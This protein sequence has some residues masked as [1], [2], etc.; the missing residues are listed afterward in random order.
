[1]SPKRKPSR[2][3][4]YA[5][6]TEIEHFEWWC[7][8]YLRQSVDQFAGLPLVLEPWQVEF[9]GEALAVDEDLRPVWSSVA[10]VVSRK[11]GKTALLAAYALWRLLNDDGQPEILLAAASDKQAGRLFD[12]VV[13]YVR[14]TPEI[15]G[16]V[17]LREYIG[18]I[19]RVDGGGK[20]LRMAS[21]PNTLH[22]YNP[23]LVICDELHA[24]TKPS[25]RSAWSALTSGGGGRKRTQ[26]FTITT[27]GEAELRDGSILGGLIDRNEKDGELEKTDGLTVSRNRAAQTLIYN[28][29]A[30][31]ADPRDVKAMKLANPSSWITEEYLA[32]QAANPELTVSEVLR[33]HGCVWAA[34]TNA[35]I[36]VEQW[37][38]CQDEDL[39]PR[40]PIPD[41]SPVY[42]GIDVGLVHDSTA[43]VL[44]WIR[45]D[46]RVVVDSYVWA[47]K[48]DA[49]ADVHVDGGV[50]ELD[51]VEEH[52]RMLA[53]TYRVRGFVYDKRFFQ[54][55]A[56]ILSREGLPMVNFEQNTAAMAEAYDEWY[57]AVLE[58]RLAHNGNRVLTAHVM[59]T[60]A[61]KT[62]RGWKVSK[63]RQNQ[64]IDATVAGVMALY[65][66]IRN[67]RESK[68]EHAGL[69]VL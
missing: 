28:Y 31:T 21:D 17:H 43:V 24:W 42:A 60:A 36:T 34:G 14:R 33:L 8:T 40:Q 30:P 27:A 9:M 15:A 10:L 46:K 66:A 20:V 4:Q 29:S 61:Q 65:S 54:R 1:M 7:A 11:N 57:A 22:G 19:A 3:E 41:G 63:I 48:R 6:G 50:V 32:R 49:A 58:G 68:Y 5:A 67:T 39:P 45:E 59:G 2:W 53:E 18:E 16:Q 25:Q 55:S 69:L 56:E 52:L 38:A 44:A 47:A 12:A 26:V 62:D 35:W 23:S 51:M 37:Q 13:S 64:R